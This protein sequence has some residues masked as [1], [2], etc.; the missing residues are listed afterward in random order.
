MP[1]LRKWTDPSAKSML[2]PP[3]WL[4]AKPLDEAAKRQSSGAVAPCQFPLQ[5]GSLAGHV[6]AFHPKGIVVPEAAPV[7]L[8]K[9]LFASWIGKTS[10]TRMELLVPSVT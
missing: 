4:L 9:L 10:P 7:P 2:H 3:G 1:F 8:Q 6:L 5:I